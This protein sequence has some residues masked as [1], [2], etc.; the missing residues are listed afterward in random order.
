[1]L[2]KEAGRVTMCDSF[3]SRHEGAGDHLSVSR[4]VR[5]GTSDDIGTALLAELQVRP[6]SDCRTL[7]ALARALGCE[8]STI[9]TQARAFE[10]EQI[11]VFEPWG[12]ETIPRI[13]HKGNITLMALE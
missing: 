13:T 10:V 1:M 3:S 5:D 2:G 6:C 9:L 12:E 4:A 8:E 7:G 11:I